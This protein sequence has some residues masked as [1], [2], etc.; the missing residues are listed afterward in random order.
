MTPALTDGDAMSSEDYRAHIEEPKNETQFQD[1]III[2][3]IEAGWPE[4]F[5]YHTRNSRGSRKGYP[6]LS[7]VHP[8]YAIG[9]KA[10]LKMPKGKIE[11]EQIA[12][13]AAWDKVPGV[14]AFLWLPEDRREI[15]DVL[16]DPSHRP[17]ARRWHKYVS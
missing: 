6:D 14:D 3:A 8:D 7:M 11:P 16:S 17:E 9:L 2:E 15:I 1:W 12:M 10:E 5:I 4:E 13:L